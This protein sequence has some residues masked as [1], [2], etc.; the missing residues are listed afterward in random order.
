NRQQHLDTR[1]TVLFFNNHLVYILLVSMSCFADDRWPIMVTLVVMGVTLILAWLLHRLLK[2]KSLVWQRCDPT[3]PPG[4]LG[5]PLLGE[6]LQ[7]FTWSS[8]LDMSPFFKKL[9]ESYGPIFKTNLVGKDLIVSLDTELNNYVI[10]QEE[11]V[12][13]IWYPDSFMRIL[14]ENNIMILSVTAKWLI[15]YDSSESSEELWKFYDIRGFLAF[16]LSIPGTAFYRC[17][18]GRKNL[19]KVLKQLIDGR[20]N[21]KPREPKDFLDLVINE[22]KKEEPVL[23]EKAAFNLLFALLLASFETASSA[24]TVVLK[25][26]TDNPKA[27]QELTDEHDQILKR[28]TDPN[29]EITWEEYRSMKFTSCVIHE[30]LR[31]ANI[32]RVV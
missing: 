9:L 25:F 28:R 13:Q 18:Q 5:L 1:N 6:T 20:K 3:L 24:I 22:L 16:P 4:S 12:F 17:M 11:K 8:S 30:S 31:L 29:S 15:G 7:F 19:M 21:A 23:N 10:Q 14:G 26:L 2:W 32:A 27:L